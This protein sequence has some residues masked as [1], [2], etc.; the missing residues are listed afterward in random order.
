M[1][2]Q[3][4]REEKMEGGEGNKV[5]GS[6][7]HPCLPKKETRGGFLCRNKVRLARSVQS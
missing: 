1:G 4:W 5:S 6:F 7:I 2:G 3:N